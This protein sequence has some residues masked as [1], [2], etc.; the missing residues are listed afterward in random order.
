MDY[1]LPDWLPIYFDKIYLVCGY[2]DFVLFN[3]V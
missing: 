3:Q 1:H 2:T